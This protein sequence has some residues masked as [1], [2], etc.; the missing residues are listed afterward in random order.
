M[1]THTDTGLSA[2]AARYL[3]RMSVLWVVLLMAACGGGSSPEADQTIAA[4]SACDQPAELDKFGNVTVPPE[5]TNVT[6]PTYVEEN[7]GLLTDLYPD[8]DTSTDAFYANQ[9]CDPS[10]GGDEPPAE[11]P[12]SDAD[13][14]AEIALEKFEQNEVP[15]LVTNVAEHPLPPLSDFPAMPDAVCFTKTAGTE[16]K[17]PTPCNSKIFLDSSQPF[18]G[19]DIIYVHGLATEHLTARLNH[20]PSAMGPVYP[21]NRVWPQDASEFLNTGGYFRTYAEDYWKS[22]IEEHLGQGWQWTPNDAAPVYQPKHNR[23][24]LVAW[25]SNQ[26]L[27]YAQDALMN[28]ISQAILANKN[29]VTPPGYP[30]NWDKPFCANGC[31]LISHSTGSLIVS[32]AMAKAASE[33]YGKGGVQIAE[34]MAA[35][36]SFNGAISGSRVATIGLVLG[37]AISL[38]VADSNVICDVF[39][40]FLGITGNSTNSCNADTSYLA[41]SILVDLVPAV[42][43]TVW[44]PLVNKTP[45]PTVTFAGGHPIGGYVVTGK[46]L[47]GVDDGVVTMDS[48][49]GNPNPVQPGLFSPSGVTVFSM[50]KAFD[51]TEF[52]GRLV[53]NA[54]VLTAEK[55]LK[56]PFPTPLYLAAA[57]SPWLSPTGMVLPVVYAWAGTP[58]DAR[59]RYHNHYSFVQ[60]IAEHSHDG[61]KPDWPSTL[62]DPASTQRHYL[63]FGDDNLEES[64]AVTDSTIYTRTI[65]TNGTHLVKPVP[66]R[67]F[68]R[69]RQVGFNL[70]FKIK[71]CRQDGLANYYCKRWLWK[72]TY[73]LLDN[74]EQKQSSH[75]AYEFVGRR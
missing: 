5:A 65:D 22:H 3:R 35:H 33:D 14:S 18:E 63:F 62:G 46:W 66:V 4:L 34:R 57:C 28:Q 24:M 74:W 32:T 38:P 54:G 39:N 73:H 55:N 67:E 68:V 15:A 44:G 56:V 30:A 58:H 64:R 27:A 10:I 40:V 37:M 43:Q 25:S 59:N 19:R 16:V 26:R 52:G 45:V 1:A 17:T 50:I 75:Y 12:E 70:P 20:P 60:S 49:C 41:N 61:G 21:A 72:R 6:A 48:A 2:V 42:T 47:P 71:G 8:I 36:I 53:R 69:G 23:Y 11:V 51:M 13:K 7:R 31:I 29:V 9:V